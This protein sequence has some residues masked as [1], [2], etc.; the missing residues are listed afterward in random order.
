MSEFKI[1]S[2]NL[3]GARDENKRAS[4]S[5]CAPLKNW[6]LSL[7]KRLVVLLIMKLIGRE[8]GRGMFF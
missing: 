3:N 8:N 5:D 7:Y 4:F 2:L 1:G 6:T